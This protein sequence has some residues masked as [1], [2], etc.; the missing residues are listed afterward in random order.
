[1]AAQV[2]APAIPFPEI[3]MFVSCI[4]RGNF[5]F[6]DSMATCVKLKPAIFYYLYIFYFNC[7][8]LID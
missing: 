6:I 2:H 4:N 3:N 7:S 8:M 1:M 5:P